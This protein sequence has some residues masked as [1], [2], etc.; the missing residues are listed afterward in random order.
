MMTRINFGFHSPDA[1]GLLF[2]NV[3]KFVGY[4]FL[5]AKRHFEHAFANKPEVFHN[6]NW[7]ATSNENIR[8]KKWHFFIGCIE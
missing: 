3:A 6:G 5:C 8:G 1:W 2:E 7:V 4:N